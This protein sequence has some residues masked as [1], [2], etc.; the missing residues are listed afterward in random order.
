LRIYKRFESGDVGG[1][2]R[3]VSE[4]SS[5]EGPH[6]WNLFDPDSNFSAMMLIWNFR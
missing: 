4:K 2:F 1:I 6:S 5:Y 3:N